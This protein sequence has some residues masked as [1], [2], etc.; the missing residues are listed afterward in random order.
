MY[1]SL[2]LFFGPDSRYLFTRRKFW[3]LVRCCTFISVVC[4]YIMKQFWVILTLINNWLWM[5]K[6]RV[7]F[8]FFLSLVRLS[9]SNWMKMRLAL[10]PSSKLGNEVKLL[11]SI[12]WSLTQPKIYF[13]LWFQLDACLWDIRRAVFL[14]KWPWFWTTLQFGWRGWATKHKLC[15]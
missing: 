9:E 6:F 12:N 13:K 10:V 4:V 11:H 1:L 14:E 3:I 2:S 5:V 15:I 8:P 7:S